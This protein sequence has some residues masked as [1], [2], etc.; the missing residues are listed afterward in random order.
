[1]SAK[2]RAKIFIK[3]GGGSIETPFLSE[4]TGKYIDEIESTL[5]GFKSA[6]RALALEALSQRL[7]SYY[8]K[9]NVTTLFFVGMISDIPELDLLEKYYP[10]LGKYIKSAVFEINKRAV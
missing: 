7:D 5:P 8:M 6:L 4:N 3:R 2:D 10:D 1:M 9:P